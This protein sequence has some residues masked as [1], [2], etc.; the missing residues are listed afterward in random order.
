MTVHIQYKDKEY[1]K[2]A[3]ASME[4]KEQIKIS[5]SAVTLKPEVLPG[6]EITIPQ[7]TFEDELD[8][9][10]KVHFFKFS[11]NRLVGTKGC[12]LRGRTHLICMCLNED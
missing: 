10:L 9:S 12:S 11:L 4:R 2:F 1:S 5:K 3:I 6:T 7:N 8:L